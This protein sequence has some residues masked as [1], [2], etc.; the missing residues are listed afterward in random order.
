M[1]NFFSAVEI[2]G[3]E[4]I[5]GTLNDESVGRIAKSFINQDNKSKLAINK[6]YCPGEGRSEI[7]ELKQQVSS[8]SVIEQLEMT[9][10][11]IIRTCK[12]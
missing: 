12:G 8:Q 5:R 10:A 1:R 3:V 2:A 7:E 11:K 9:Q 4:N 6:R